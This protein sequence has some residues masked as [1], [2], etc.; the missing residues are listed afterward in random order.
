[1]RC[2]RYYVFRKDGGWSV[3]HG[4]KVC[5]SFNSKADAIRAAI[6][7]AHDFGDDFHGAEVLVEGEAGEY[8]K[9]WTYGQDHYPPPA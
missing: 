6:E 5:C 2:M 4:N 9:I 7:T 3:K 1:M 8:R